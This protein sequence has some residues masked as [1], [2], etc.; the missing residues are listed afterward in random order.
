MGRPVT[1]MCMFAASLLSACSGSSAAQ[2]NSTDI[3]G[4]VPDLAFALTRAQDGAQVSAADYR[5][6]MVLLYFGYTYC[7][8]VCPL[9]LS[10]VAQVLR[11]MGPSSA[12]HVRVLFI[13]VDPERDTLPALKRYA[14]AFGSNFAGLRGT[15]DE[16][17]TLAKR[18]RVAYSSRPD[19][20]PSRYDVTHSS[21]LYAFDGEGRAR[22]L[23]TSLSAADPDIDGVAAD[24]QRIVN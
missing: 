21:A 12:A 7:P 8:D 4:N 23:I 22:L 17:A 5:G 20:D 6:D 16:L 9:T 2:W 19:P 15:P 3:S 18:Y 1:A 10:N 24:L 13:T 11:R 14:A